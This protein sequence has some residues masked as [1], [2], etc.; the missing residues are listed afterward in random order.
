MRSASRRPAIGVIIADDA[1]ADPMDPAAMAKRLRRTAKALRSTAKHVHRHWP[2]PLGDPSRHYVEDGAQTNLH[3]RS[4]EVIG[5]CTTSISSGES[6]TCTVFSTNLYN[7]APDG[8]RP[9]GLGSVITDRDCFVANGARDHGPDRLERMAADDE[10]L[11][12]ALENP[13]AFAL[14]QAFRDHLDRLCD[15]ACAVAHG[16][17]ARRTFVRAPG[18]GQTSFEVGLQTGLDRFSMRPSPMP[19]TLPMDS[20]VVVLRRLIPSQDLLIVTSL[21]KDRLA[22]PDPVEALRILADTDDIEIEHD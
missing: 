3:D 7:F 4:G 13:A 11:A 17:G 16:V 18:P 20:R 14:G 1:M 2:G 5:R 10:A 22:I 19:S 15:R 9:H 21:R 6:G 8:S 12:K